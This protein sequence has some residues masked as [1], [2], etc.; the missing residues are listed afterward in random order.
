[1]P[2][3]NDAG[4]LS[5]LVEYLTHTQDP[6]STRLFDETM[7]DHGIDTGGTLITYAQ[8]LLEKGRSEGRQEGRE[9]GRMQRDLEVIQGSLQA[10]VAWDVIT[11]ATGLTEASFEEL[12]A[13][14]AGSDS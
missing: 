10:G 2:V 8:E 13:R 14:L 1:M 11:T 3:A 6:E 7:K 12:K 9:E 4:N 5:L